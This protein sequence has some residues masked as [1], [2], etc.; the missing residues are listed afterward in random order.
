MRH[1][2][3][4]ALPHKKAPATLADIEALPHGVTGQIIHGELFA[5]ARP[6]SPHTVTISRLGALL[7]DAFD[8]RR[9][10]NGPDERWLIIH[11]PELHVGPRPDVLV[12]DLAGWR[13]ARMPKRPTTASISLAP[14][15]VCEALSRGTERFDRMIKLPVYARE[16]VGHVWLLNPEEQT[17]EVFSREGGS[18]LLLTVASTGTEVALPPFEAAPLDLD[19]LWGD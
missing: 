8:R 15:W 10:P 2:P 19:F 1:P 14:D 6:A 9:G 13:R 7:V 5:H 16:G 3:D 18:W 12:P 17:I 11:E 4:V